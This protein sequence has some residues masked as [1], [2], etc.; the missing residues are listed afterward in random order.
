MLLRRRE[1]SHWHVRRQRRRSLGI[2]LDPLGRVALDRGAINDTLPLE[3][4]Q[5]ASRSVQYVSEG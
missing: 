5:Y 1:L 4:G 2:E 3:P